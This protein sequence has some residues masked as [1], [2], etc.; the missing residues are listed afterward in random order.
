MLG[1]SDLLAALERLKAQGLTTNAQL[2]RLL[3]LPSSRIAEIFAGRRQ[4]TIDEMKLMVEHFGLEGASPAPSAETLEPILDALLPLAP[5]GK[6][7]DQSR[8]ALAEALAYG[9]E[10]LGAPSASPASPD[11][12]KVAARAAA[13]RF[14]ETATAS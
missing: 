12:L 13:V 9:L 8:R 11:A 14:R 1:S 3:G 6:L 5:P 2:S 4:V 10:L 7:T